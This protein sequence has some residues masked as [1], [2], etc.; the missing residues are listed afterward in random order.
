MPHLPYRLRSPQDGPEVGALAPGPRAGGAAAGRAA[1]GNVNRNKY[2]FKEAR[3]PI[4]LQRPVPSDIEI[5]QAAE[6]RPVLDIA[7]E[8]GLQP[9]ELELFGKYKAKVHLE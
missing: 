2:L 7:A 6:L 5:A 1:A 8:V 3:V 4:T 9:D